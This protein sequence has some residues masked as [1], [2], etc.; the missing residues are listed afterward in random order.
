MGGAEKRGDDGPTDAEKIAAARLRHLAT[1]YSQAGGVRIL[2]MSIPVAIIINGEPMVAGMMAD[3]GEWV[4]MDRIE[5]LHGIPHGSVRA[6]S[7]QC[8]LPTA[9]EIQREAEALR[10]KREKTL[11]S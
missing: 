6:Y 8:H 1:D 5:A 10:K 7:L 9:E 3:S 4:C 11:V 2:G